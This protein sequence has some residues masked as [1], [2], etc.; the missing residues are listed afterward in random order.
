MWCRTSSISL[1][2]RVL[3]HTCLFMSYFTLLG[4]SPYIFPRAPPGTLQMA[5]KKSSCALRIPF[6]ARPVSFLALQALAPLGL[7]R[8]RGPSVS[9][10]EGWSH[11]PSKG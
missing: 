9:P 3:G 7:Q 6:R 4:L 5:P 1:A 2:A 11:T 8:H 10:P